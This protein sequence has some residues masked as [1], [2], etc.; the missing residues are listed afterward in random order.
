ME[1]IN[2]RI[3]RRCTGAL[4]L[5]GQQGAFFDLSVPLAAVR[6]RARFVGQRP[7]G[8]PD[9]IEFLYVPNWPQRQNENRA[10]AIVAALQGYNIGS[11]RMSADSEYGASPV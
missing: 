9:R 10:K 4:T 2:M 8:E 3:L 1:Q 7:G 5:I 11:F 6:C